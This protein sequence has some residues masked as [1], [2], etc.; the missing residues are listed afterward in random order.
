MI[1]TPRHHQKNNIRVNGFRVP[2]ALDPGVEVTAAYWRVH[3]GVTAPVLGPKPLVTDKAAREFLT[4]IEEGSEIDH[5]K[6]AA[7]VR[8][9]GFHLSLAVATGEFVDYDGL[10]DERAHAVAVLR[11]TLD[12][13]ALRNAAQPVVER[14]AAELAI[15]LAPIQCMH[16]QSRYADSP[17]LRQ[18]MGEDLEVRI[19]PSVMA[20]PAP[21]GKSG[22]YREI[23]ERN[24]LT[25]VLGVANH[26]DLNGNGYVDFPQWWRLG[27]WHFMGRRYWRSRLDSLGLSASDKCQMLEMVPLNYLVKVGI[28]EAVIKTNTTWDDYLLD[29]LIAATKVIG[30]YEVTGVLSATAQ[31]NW[32]YS[33]GRFHVGWFLDQIGDRQFDDINLGRLIERWRGDVPDLVPAKPA[34]RGPLGACENPLWLRDRPMRLWFSPSISRASRRV[35]RLWLSSYWDVHPTEVTAVVFEPSSDDAV[36]LVFGLWGDEE[37][38]APARKEVTR[39]VGSGAVADDLCAQSPTVRVVYAVGQQ[40]TPSSW[41]RVC[42]APSDG[43]I[44]SIHSHAFHYSDWTAF[45]GDTRDIGVIVAP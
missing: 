36:D 40:E 6:V 21:N 11:Q 30:E 15:E 25:L 24:R 9:L 39:L 26:I 17:R 14:V 19:V 28:H 22:F 45:R 34:F 2:L 41:R 20:L 38:V 32:F 44:E 42:L 29:Q 7:A 8:I 33:L 37:W 1:T 27:V 18:L 12:D 4:E 31:K 10:N 43:E 5:E 3:G 35:I 13:P 23:G 16:K